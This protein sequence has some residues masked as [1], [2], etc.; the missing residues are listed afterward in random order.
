VG[1]TGIEEEDKCSNTI[2]YLI[3]TLLMTKNY[4]TIS[5]VDVKA[6]LPSLQWVDILEVTCF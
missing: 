2:N 1:A 6:I 3:I 5:T 4:T